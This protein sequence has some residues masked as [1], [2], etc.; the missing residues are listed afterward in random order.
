[1]KRCPTRELATIW[2]ALTLRS[3]IGVGLADDS[4]RSRETT[5]KKMIGAIV[6]AAVCVVVQ[7]HTV[8]AQSVPDPDRSFM[9]EAARGGIAEVELS[10]IA[11]QRAVTEPVRQFGQRMVTDHGAANQELMQLAQSKGVT[12]PQEMDAAHRATMD[13]LMTLSGAAFDQ[14]YMTEMIRD[15]QGAA[16]LFMREAR[17][18]QDAHVREWALK[19]VPTIQEHQRLAYDIHSRIAQAPVPPAPAAVVA[20]PAAVAASPA[21]V[22]VITTTTPLPPFCG[23]TYLPGVG[24]NFSSCPR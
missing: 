1:M 22:T 8:R 21:T 12:L 19:T 9:I 13:R 4:V 15:H 11:G 16:A 17:Q 2:P 24:T 10:R 6:V 7:A 18:G 14:A 23:G 20:P 3:S 5:M